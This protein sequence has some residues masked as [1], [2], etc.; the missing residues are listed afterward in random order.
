MAI[1][2]VISFRVD[3]GG[4]ND[5]PPKTRGNDRWDTGRTSS[6]LSPFTSMLNESMWHLRN[7]F[8][9]GTIVPWND[10]LVAEP[11]SFIHCKK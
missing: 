4:L 11:D 7:F 6:I 1:Q 2:R 10:V 8:N 5:M 9:K 3:D